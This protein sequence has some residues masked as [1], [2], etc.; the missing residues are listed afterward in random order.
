MS[1]KKHA[2]SKKSTNKAG[3]IQKT[4]ATKKVVN[5]KIEKPSTD[6]FF[7]YLVYRLNND[8]IT[9]EILLELVSELEKQIQH[10]NFSLPNE[11]EKRVGKELTDEIMILTVKAESILNA[12]L[13]KNIPSDEVFSETIF[14]TFSVIK[15]IKN[16]V[17]VN[18]R[19]NEFRIFVET[20]EKK[21]KELTSLPI[22]I[23]IDGMVK[24]ILLEI[25][26][27]KSNWSD[28]VIEDEE[29]SFEIPLKTTQDLI[30][31]FDEDYL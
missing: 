22:S 11:F 13:K 1:K 26:N 16:P 14:F 8:D 31:E 21:V 25:S 24:D 18:K 10:N 4:T 2:Q 15:L 7:E 12:L 27:K 23:D 20:W 28:P 6:D 30:D 29:D 17:K 9:K 19:I 5:P 3:E